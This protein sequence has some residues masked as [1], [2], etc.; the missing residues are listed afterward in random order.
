MSCVHYKFF[1]ELSYDTVIFDGLHIS[2]S[3]LKKQIMKKEK[4][5]AT[6]CDLQI[7]NAETKEEYSDD[8][9]LIH[10]NLSVIVRRI[11]VGGVVSTSRTYVLDLTKQVSRTSK[12]KVFYLQKCLYICME[13]EL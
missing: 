4:L 9:A 11:P 13:V 7:S 3:D 6:N 12:A 8:N 10:K 5:K 2:L 1:S